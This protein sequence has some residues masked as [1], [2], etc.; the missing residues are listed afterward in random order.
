[1]ALYH[2]SKSTTALDMPW[3]MKRERKTFNSSAGNLE[4][5]WKGRYESLKICWNVPKL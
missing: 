4:V 5:I 1:M 2:N 3:L